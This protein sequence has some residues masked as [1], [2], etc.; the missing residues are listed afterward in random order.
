MMDMTCSL[1]AW[2]FLTVASRE[3]VWS[4][5]VSLA[6]STHCSVDSVSF[7]SRKSN[8]HT[9]TV[10]SITLHITLVRAIGRYLEGFVGFF[11]GFDIGIIVESNQFSWKY[12]CC[13][14]LL[15]R[16]RRESNPSGER[17][18]NFYC[19]SCPGQEQGFWW[20]GS[21][22]S[23][24]LLRKVYYDF[25]LILFNVFFPVLPFLINSKKVEC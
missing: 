3:K 21:L 18:F 14:I 15:C 5:V 17:C 23:T 25:L 6:L 9:F 2:A 22:G 10:H 4:I 12:T 1:F 13:H 24:P 20:L 19:G 11:P 8:S 7:W 16:A